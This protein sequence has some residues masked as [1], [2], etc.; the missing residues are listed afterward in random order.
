MLVQSLQQTTYLMI[1]GLAGEMK[2]GKSIQVALHTASNQAE[3][4]R[5]H[6]QAERQ[7]A[8]VTHQVLNDALVSAQAVH[9]QLRQT[10]FT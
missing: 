2:R 6:V 9:L 8:S 1:Q 5:E 3:D 7:S 10:V 4:V